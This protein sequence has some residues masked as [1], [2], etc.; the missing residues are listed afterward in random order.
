MCDRVTSSKE[1]TSQSQ[2]W[3]FVYA[4]VSLPWR[5][6]LRH[7]KRGGSVRERVSKYFLKRLNWNWILT[8]RW[9][10]VAKIRSQ[11]GVF[12]HCKCNFQ[13]F[14]PIA[15]E[16]LENSYQICFF[17]SHFLQVEPL[18]IP[19]PIAISFLDWTTV[20]SCCLLSLCGKL[21][22]V[23]AQIKPD[24]VEILIAQYIQLMCSEFSFIT[25][26]WMGRYLLIIL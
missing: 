20:W 2:E 7:K 3:F 18:I 12:L 22:S 25:S 9:T 19:I 13:V 15:Q 11:G 26:R 6:T 8:A 1:S 16:A 23:H 14:F 10:V 5:A 24:G 4:P 17:M 21:Y